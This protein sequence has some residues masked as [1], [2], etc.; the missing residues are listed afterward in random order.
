MIDFFMREIK[1]S[2]ACTAFG[3]QSKIFLVKQL[4]FRFS[5]V[6]F[7]LVCGWLKDLL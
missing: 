2:R 4:E 3:V 7:G 1:K 6:F 5:C